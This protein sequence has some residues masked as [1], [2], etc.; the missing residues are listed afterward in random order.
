MDEITS[1]VLVVGGGLAGFTSA[2]R[3]A[4][5]GAKV[6]L[7]DKSDKPL[8]DGNSLMTSGSLGAGGKSP[9]TLVV[10]LYRCAM[11]EGIAIP[12][13]AKSWA[14]S[15]G[16][17]VDWLHNVGVALAETAPGR[18]WL[19]QQSEISLAPV[20][21]KDVGRRALAQLRSRLLTLGGRHCAGVEAQEL[22]REQF[23]VRGVMARRNGAAIALRSRATVLCTGGFSANPAMLRRYI[24]AHADQCKLRGS[25]QCSGDGLRLALA[26]GAKTVNL[27]YFYGHL[28][29]RNALDDDRFWPY[30]R[31]DNL[32]EEGLLVDRTA[33]RFVDEGRGD[34]AVANELA[35]TDDVTGATLIFD[36]ATW[37]AARD[38]PASTSRAIPSANPWLWENQ[39]DIFCHNQIAGL[40]KILGV[41][42]STLTTTVEQYNRA[43]AMHD[44]LALPVVRTGNPKPLQAPYYGLRV[45]P[46]ITFTM[47][48][49][50][51]NGRGQVLN[52]HDHPIPGLYAAGDAIGGLMG[53]YKGGYLGGLMQ[54]IVTGLLAGETAAQQA[55]GIPG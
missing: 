29:A 41:E 24:G 17:A 33:R 55:R 6:V 47:G 19:D 36:H 18:L 28:I 27:P 43:V 8:G 34:V 13:L 48:G 25:P 15:C 21:K 9:K 16:R 14:E 44:T 45:V 32:L 4:E 7:I 31:L 20:Y 10:D 54:A 3:A 39:A 46:G 40:A 12:D 11:A 22:I 53:G 30:P 2:V 23:Q 5:S 38:K 42:G 37:S 51:I 49:A 1:D 26:T 52:L 50:A 35:R